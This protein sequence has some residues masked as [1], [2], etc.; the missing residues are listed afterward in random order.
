[1]RKTL[2]T[3]LMVLASTCLIGGFSIGSTTN[4]YAQPVN[5]TSFVIL[6]NNGQVEDNKQLVELEV[7]VPFFDEQ[8]N[9]SI[10]ELIESKVENERQVNT[11][12]LKVS[13]DGSLFTE[14]NY[15]VTTNSNG[16]RALKINWY[17]M[18]QAPVSAVVRGGV[19][20]HKFSGNTYQMDIWT[21]PARPSTG[22]QYVNK[23]FDVANNWTIQIEVSSVKNKGTSN[24]PIY[25]R[26]VTVKNY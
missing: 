2:I 3:K 1:M 18:V 17:N 7:G 22:V 21:T 11:Y 10:L 26:T 24:T 5:E 6:N 12:T 14:V 8:G 4:V 20:I 9:V 13:G 25:V 19:S 16:T 15:T 23:T